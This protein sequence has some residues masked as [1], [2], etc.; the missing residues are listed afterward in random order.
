MFCIFH[1]QIT[2]WFANF[3]YFCF[4]KNLLSLRHVSEWLWGWNMEKC[5][6]GLEGPCWMVCSI[7]PSSCWSQQQFKVIFIFFPEGKSFCSCSL[8]TDQLCFSFVIL[9]YL[10]TL[11][12]G[13]QINPWGFVIFVSCG[14]CGILPPGNV[15]SF[16]LETR[17][18]SR[19]DKQYYWVVPFGNISVRIFFGLITLQANSTLSCRLDCNLLSS[20]VHGKLVK[21]KLSWLHGISNYLLS[22][23]R[24]MWFG[25][26]HFHS[27]HVTS[28]LS[29][30]L[31]HKTRKPMFS[32]F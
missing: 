4:T 22:W 6:D 19:L 20:K 18:F 10:Y 23:L 11:M 26:A 3:K 1:P 13:L 14:L 9:S 17:L 25:H 12:K 32:M 24:L 29:H 8:V 30:K 27:S 28:K 31:L 15:L 7:R 21:H 5:C 2:K 16:I